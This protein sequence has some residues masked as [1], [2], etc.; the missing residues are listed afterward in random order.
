MRRVTLE[1]LLPPESMTEF[2]QLIKGKEELTIDDLKTF[3]RKYEK[4]LAAKDVVPDYLAY[5]FMHH[6]QE[7]GALS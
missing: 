1:E 2:H 5:A 4:E 6:L 7:S 3:F